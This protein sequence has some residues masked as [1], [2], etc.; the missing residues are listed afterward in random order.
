M[1]YPFFKMDSRYTRARFE[2]IASQALDEEIEQKL[3]ETMLF[4]LSSPPATHLE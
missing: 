2:S 3:P 1:V 4:F